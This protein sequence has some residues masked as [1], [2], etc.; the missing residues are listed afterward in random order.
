MYFVY[1]IKCS[2]KSLYTG[3]TT[4]LSRRFSE[5]KAGIG[6]RYTRSKKVKKIVYSEECPDR[7]T[8][9]KRELQIKALRR[10]KKLNLINQASKATQF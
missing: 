5:H 8:A 3:V 4:N 2:D 6:S 7:S 9:L 1:I 10:E